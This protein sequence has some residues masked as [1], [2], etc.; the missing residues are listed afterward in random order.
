MSTVHIERSY[1]GVFDTVFCIHTL[2]DKYISLTPQHVVRAGQ[3]RS[4][5]TV[6]L[7]NA[8]LLLPTVSLVYFQNHLNKLI[9]SLCSSFSSQVGNLFGRRKGTVVTLLSGTFDSSTVVMFVIKVSCLLCIFR[10]HI[11]S[12]KSEASHRVT[13]VPSPQHTVL[14]KTVECNEYSYEFDQI[15]SISFWF[16]LPFRNLV[17]PFF[18]Q[19]R[20]TTC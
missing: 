11:I 13:P 1:H 12:E 5:Q 7:L 14:S 15:I 10:D 17:E 18:C 8:G 2:Q 4:S 20:T 9:M 19:V 6:Y 3:I 16:I